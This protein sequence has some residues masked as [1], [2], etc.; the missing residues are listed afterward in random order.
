LVQVAVVLAYLLCRTEAAVREQLRATSRAAPPQR[1]ATRGDQRRSLEV[2]TCCAPLLRW[3][4]ARMPPTGQQLALAMDATTLGQRFTVLSLHV[5]IQGC[6]IPVAWHIVRATAKGA[7]RPH[8]EARFAQRDSAAPA[9]WTVVVAADQ[10]LYATWLFPTITAVGW[11]PLL[12]I[13]RQ[14]TYCPVGQTNCRPLSLVVATGG[15]PWQGQVMCFST[16]ERQRTCTLLARWEPAY[17]DPW[18][19]VTDRPPAQADVA[20]YGL[21]A[22]LGASSTDRTHDGWRWEQTTMTDP[23]RVARGWLVMALATRWVVSTVRAAEAALPTP[24]CDALPETHSARAPLPDDPH[25]VAC[26]ASTAGA[27]A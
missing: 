5:V 21:R 27:S 18:R 7:W 4:V 20:W 9:D 12:R 26:A 8:G 11:H 17:K 6:A 19:I 1:G 10:G 24:A 2:T 3:G 16:T 22:W 23:R 25:R 13:N 14:G 15:R